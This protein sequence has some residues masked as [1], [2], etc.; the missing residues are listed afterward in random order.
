MAKNRLKFL[1]ENIGNLASLQTL[2]LLENA[3]LTALPKSLC[4]AQRLKAILAT[5]ETFVY[6]PPDTMREGT[7]AIMKYICEGLYAFVILIL[8]IKQPRRQ[9]N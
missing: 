4:R 2:N 3:D 5:P 6:P 9:T 7:E 8:H 1:P